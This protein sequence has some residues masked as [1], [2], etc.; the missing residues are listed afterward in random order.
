MDI[1]AFVDAIEEALQREGAPRTPARAFKIA[2]AEEAALNLAAAAVAAG[3]F[4]TAAATNV[5]DA[6]TASDSISHAAETLG[7]SIQTL[8]RR[9]DV[10]AV[11]AIEVGNERRVPTWQYS[12][13]AP[14]LLLPH[15]EE[16]LAAARE[17]GLAGTWIAGFME[18]PQPTLVA[19]EALT[20]RCWLAG[21]RSP[22]RV[23][24]VL[25]RGRFL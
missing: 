7:L 8:S 19:T 23:I 21:G 22:D 25:M 2:G 15:L 14:R 1:D 24:E 13:R 11:L 17:R 3:S 9:I 10:G 12:D 4:Q 18:H 6:V 16:V 5:A 20:P